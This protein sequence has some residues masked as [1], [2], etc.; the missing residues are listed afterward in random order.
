[1]ADAKVDAILKW[2]SDHG[3]KFKFKDESPFMKLLGKILVFNKTFMTS[4]TT[5]IG[6]TIYFPSQAW[7]EARQPATTIAIV[8]HEVTH[9]MDNR[10]LG[11]VRYVYKYL[12]PQLNA[13]GAFGALGAIWGGPWYLLFLLCLGFLA[14]WGSKGRTELEM[15][16]YATSMAVSAWLGHPYVQPPEWV[17]VQF[18]GPAYYYMCRDKPA[19]K[20]EVRVWLGRIK[21]DSILK[22][23]PHLEAVKTICVANQ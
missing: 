17:M 22:E 11:T 16:G 10:K 19:V 3:V 13:L 21:N 7:L 8:A 9:V 12:S 14:P 6:N 2:A 15:R 4:F 5:T 18:S 1:M 20:A 23:L